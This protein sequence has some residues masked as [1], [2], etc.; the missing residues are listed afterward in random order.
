[1]NS[2]KEVK[3]L[4]NGTY[5]HIGKLNLRENE[6]WKYLMFISWKELRCIEI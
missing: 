3:H 1:M 2:T 5:K 4:Y 6:K